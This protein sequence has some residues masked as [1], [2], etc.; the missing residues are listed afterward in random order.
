M[1]VNDQAY[2]E[3]RFASKDW[4]QYGG[5]DQTR[6]FMQVLVDYLPDWL[7]AEWQEKEYTVC[8]AG[9]AK[10]EGAAL[11]AQVFPKCKVFGMDFSPS[12]IQ[13][14]A[15]MYP[16]ASFYVGDIYNWHETYDVIVSSNVLEHLEHP[17][18]VMKNML[19]NTREYLV[20]MVPLDDDY[21]YDEHINRFSFDSFNNL[22]DG[23]SLAYHTW[24][25]S[26]NLPN[27]M[28]LGYQLLLVYRKDKKDKDAGKEKQLAEISGGVAEKASFARV[29]SEKETAVQQIQTMEQE[30]VQL[31]GQCSTLEQEK[32][33]LSEQCNGLEQEKQQLTEQCGSL[34]QEYAALEQEKR[35]AVEALE[36]QLAE[37]AEKTDHAFAQIK[38]EE[39]KTRQL[40]AYAEDTFSIY[41]RQIQLQNQAI[42]EALVYN[43]QMMDA[44]MFKLIH[45]FGRI[46]R[47]LLL[48][49]MQ[50]KRRFFSWLT[51]RSATVTDG[52]HRFQPLYSV[53]D[54]LRRV[55]HPNCAAPNLPLDVDMICRPE[56]QG[57]L[58]Q[59]DIFTS[60]FVDHIKTQNA[61]FDQ[62]IYQAKT[63]GAAQ[64]ADMIKHTACKGIMV[65]PHT[66]NWEPLQTPQQLLRAFAKR[67]WLCLFCEHPG[68][69]SGVRELEKNLYMVTEADVI[70]AVG[71]TEVTVLL[72][73][74]G[75]M[76]FVDHLPNKKIWYNVLDKIDIFGLYDSVFEMLHYKMVQKSDWISYVAK[77]LLSYAPN[78]MDAVHLPN[79]CHPAELVQAAKKEW[80]VPVDLQPILQLGHKI[81]GYFGYIESWMNQDWIRQAALARPDYEFVFIGSVRVDISALEKLPNVHFLG[82]KKYQELPA[83][84][85]H[86]DVATIPFLINEMMDCVSPIK[87]YEYCAFGKP[88]VTSRMKEMEDYECA[89]VSCVDNG[90]EFLAK[91][92]EFLK[93]EIAQLAAK[94]AP[95]IALENSWDK[96]AQTMERHFKG[97]KYEILEKDYTKY[98]VIILAVIDYDFRYQ[99]PQHFAARFAENGHRVFYINANHF[100]PT[101]VQEI[102]PNLYIVNINHPTEVAIHVTD[103]AND[104]NL[105]KGHFDGLIQDYCIRDAVTIVDYP[106]WIW[107]A[108]YLRE[109]YGFKMIVDYMDDFT[110]FLN[111]A[112]KLVGSNC[113][114]MLHS[115]DAVI[116]SS[117]FLSDIA[118]KYQSVPGIVRNGTEYAFFHEAY[119]K[120]VQKQRPV[121]GYYGAVAHWFDAQKVCYLAEHLP[122]CDIVIIGAVTDWES[123]LSSHSN[124]Q[125]L[126]EKPYQE[127]PRYLK[128]F[129]VCL[130]PFDTSTDLIKATNPVKF[131]EYLSAGK[132]VVATEIPELEPYRDRYVYMANDNEQFLAYVKQCLDGTDTLAGP[133]E[134]AEFAAEND[135]QKRYEAFRDLIQQAVPKISIVVLTYNNLKCNK[136]CIDSIL[137][138]TAY[139]AY[140]L[141]IVDNASTDGTVEWLKE[142]DQKHLP[143]VTVVLNKENLGFAAGNNVGMKLAK[144][145]YVVLLN[146][147]TLVTRGWLSGMVKHLENDE[148]LGM[149][150]PVTNSIGNE[151]KIR[152]DYFDKEGLEL[153][154]N[155]YTFEH[156][157]ELWQDPGVLALFCTMIKRGVIDKCG[158]L[159]EAYGRGMFEDDDYSWAARKAGYRIAIAEDSFIHHFEG[160]SFKK[161]ED[162]SFK[163]LFE[164]NKSIFEKK[165]NTEWKVHQK[166]PGVFWDTNIHNTIE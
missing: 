122:Q 150:G 106:N 43:Q 53:Q 37:Q 82:L 81:V 73:W 119:G 32:Q 40:C 143:N 83:Y 41:Y 46:K 67:G 85:V 75:S 131:Y 34:K 57:I 165:W 126:G 164:K 66:V 103:W 160:M 62:V 25:Y 108:E 162:K 77:P 99:R 146:N 71:N 28:W 166:R 134:C 142:L 12:A 94:E 23:F 30:K 72:T 76:A 153:F 135:W 105:L 21:G 64:L 140:E 127:L 61:Y 100:Q 36:Q 117:Q 144:G 110:G 35:A 121:I 84:T 102:S 54:A 45:L 139:P 14:A 129:D 88:V 58:K 56:P 125:L 7:K 29:L 38:E 5:Q 6:F 112:E 145:D 51:H 55:E 16:Q 133:E 151:A 13:E 4:D 147:D 3:E 123:D 115:C 91:I 149:C 86:F 161:L 93:P 136:G 17:D 132:K 74:M 33:Q 148:A 1:K 111:P 98:D 118:Q 11:L 163:E 70:Q 47:Q 69:H 50:E 87:F 26:G 78:R 79:G 63:P 60:S 68:I 89:F 159:D 113:V 157:G 80:P 90:R 42:H 18:Q 92:D 156:L 152:V 19:K 104:M 24:I 155:R 48:G 20:L 101:G 96:R 158:Y 107:G 8:D 22:Y 39:R 31:A 44:K 141:I 109:T 65:Y 120:N 137:R 27:T 9:C 124:I 52:D 2:W 138:K 116:P 97:G 130:I 59:M 10:G 114:K 128:D 95:Q 49:N 154:A 15:R